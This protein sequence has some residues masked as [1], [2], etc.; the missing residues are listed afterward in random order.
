[1][2]K[3]DYIMYTATMLRLVGLVSGA[4]LAARLIV[5]YKRLDKCVDR[6]VRIAA[7]M[8]FVY[9]LASVYGSFSALVQRIPPTF[10]S[11]VYFGLTA[12][13]VLGHRFLGS[14]YDTASEDCE[15]A[16]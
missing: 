3:A 5:G 4:S 8:A 7:M 2:T 6:P 12:G 10:G 11:L 13:A 14:V 16:R 15:P 9:S 1:M